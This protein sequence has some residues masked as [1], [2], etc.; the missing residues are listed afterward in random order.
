MDYNEKVSN[1][2]W[3]FIVGAISYLVGRTYI[4]RK[5]VTVI[6]NYTAKPLYDFILRKGYIAVETK[7]AEK[8]EDKL[9][10]TTTIEEAKKA[11]DDI[12]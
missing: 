9:D 11:V 7:R 5:L 6:L 12:P 4:V 1:G 2:V 3:G 10:K 8:A